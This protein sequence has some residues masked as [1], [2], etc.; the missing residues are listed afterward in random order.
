MVFLMKKLCADLP[1]FLSISL[2]RSA[3][4][5]VATAAAKVVDKWRA[6][7]LSEVEAERKLQAHGGGRS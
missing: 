1:P 6:A 4:L 2:K 7:I 5:S 3:H